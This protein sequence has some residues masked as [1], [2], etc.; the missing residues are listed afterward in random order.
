MIT[1]S[2]V[3]KKANIHRE[4]FE[5]HYVNPFVMHYEQYMISFRIKMEILNTVRR[6]EAI[7]FTFLQMLHHLQQNCL[8]EMFKIYSEFIIICICFF[9]TV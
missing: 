2:V 4:K 9:F 5:S 8:S 7:G 6:T 1:M 3:Q